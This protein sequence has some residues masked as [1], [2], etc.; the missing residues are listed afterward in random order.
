[1][2]PRVNGSSRRVVTYFADDH[3]EAG[4]GERKRTGMAGDEKRVNGFNGQSGL[5]NGRGPHL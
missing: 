1:M 4:T 2:N 3:K 5:R